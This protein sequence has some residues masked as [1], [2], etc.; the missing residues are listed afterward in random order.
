MREK[1]TTLYERKR[2]CSTKSDL[3]LKIV[4]KMDYGKWTTETATNH[5]SF[6]RFSGAPVNKFFYLLPTTANIYLLA[7][8]FRK[9]TDILFYII[10]LSTQDVV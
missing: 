10:G 7:L 4:K 3:R 2:N 5:N 9:I 1:L 8:C 6:T